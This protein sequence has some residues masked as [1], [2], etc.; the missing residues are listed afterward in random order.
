LQLG[1]DTKS[2]LKETVAATALP[3]DVTREHDENK[4]ICFVL[5]PSTWT[6][7]ASVQLSG[8]IFMKMTKTQ[9]GAAKI[10]ERL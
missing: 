10:K 2:L 8:T 5:Q 3:N 7:R 9:D 1:S 6:P 4:A